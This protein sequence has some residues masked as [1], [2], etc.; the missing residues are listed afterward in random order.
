M[1]KTY[2]IISLNGF[3]YA[4][5]KKPEGNVYIR[6]DSP[7]GTIKGSLVEMK[8]T[9]MKG[10]YGSMPVASNDPSLTDIP[11]L[12]DFDRHW[13]CDVEDRDIFYED[14]DPKRCF[15]QCDR[16]KIMNKDAKKQYTEEDI[17]TAYIWGRNGSEPILKL[18][19]SLKPIPK[20]VE[21]EVVDYPTTGLPEDMK[22]GDRLSW[23]KKDMNGFVIVKSWKYE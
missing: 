6:T 13:Y 11:K 2:P 15:I 14:K 3:L 18:L 9:G 5:E 1:T 12:P 16:C 22:L 19:Q 7:F 21:L 4:V 8:P 10:L 20:E 23:V 17:R